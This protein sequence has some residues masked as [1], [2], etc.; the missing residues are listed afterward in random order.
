MID[1]GGDDDRTMMFLVAAIEP[2][3]KTASRIGERY[4]ERHKARGKQSEFSAQRY[5]MELL[6][7]AE[8]GNGI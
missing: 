5:L 4:T 7:S 1:P 2:D 6:G 8:G 3:T